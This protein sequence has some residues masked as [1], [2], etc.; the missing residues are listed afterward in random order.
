MSWAKTVP[1]RTHW[2]GDQKA[3]KVMIPEEKRVAQGRTPETGMA[4][5]PHPE[6][7]TV[8]SSSD[9]EDTSFYQHLTE[10]YGRRIIANLI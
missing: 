9:A 1:T 3:P 5:L 6:E 4:L 8:L 10:P 2:G 7:V